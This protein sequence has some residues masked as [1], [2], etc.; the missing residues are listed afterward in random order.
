MTVKR[1]LL[2]LLPALLINRVSIV[3]H[4]NFWDGFN[5]DKDDNRIDQQMKELFLNE[6]IHKYGVD[7]VRILLV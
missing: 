2:L 5:E 4:A 3:A 1:A 6:G 7:I